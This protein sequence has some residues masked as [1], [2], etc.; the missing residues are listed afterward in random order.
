MRALTS[1]ARHRPPAPRLPVHRHARRRQDH[2][3]AHPGEVAQLRD[4]ACRAEPCG[5]CRACIEIDEGAFTDYLELDAASNRGVDEMTQLLENAVYAPAVGRYKVYVIDEV[6]MLSTHAFNAMLKTL[7]E[8]PPHMVFILATTDPQKVPVTVLSR[9][10]QFNLKNMPPAAI[11]RHLATVLAGR[12]RRVRGAGA[13]ADRPR[14]GGQHAR[15]AVAARPGDRLRRRRRCA[16][17]RSARCSAWS[18]VATSA[19]A[20]RA[21]GRRR[22]RR[23]SRVADEMMTSNAPFGRT[24]MTS[25][26]WLQRDRAR[27]RWARRRPRT[28]HFARALCAARFAPEDLQVYYQIADPRRARP[29]A[30][31]RRARRVHDDAAA[32]ARVRPE[33]SRGAAAGQGG[34]ASGRQAALAPAPRPPR[35]AR[36]REPQ[37]SRGL[38]SHRAARRAGRCGA[39]RRFAFR[40][41]ARRRRAA[42]G[43]GRRV[44]ARPAADGRSRSRRR[45]AGRRRVGRFAGPARPPDRRFDGDWPALAAAAA[46]RGSRR[47]NSC[48]R[49][50]SSVTMA[51]SFRFACRSPARR[52]RRIVAKVRQALSTHFG[53]PVR[54]GV[55]RRRGRAARRSRRRPNEPG[56]ERLAT[57]RARRSSP[58][59]SCATLIRRSSAARIVPESVARSRP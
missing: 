39:R 31:A 2:D 37:R 38:T 18:I 21:R 28:R 51:W 34:S 13:R 3:R 27:C 33:R 57:A 54:L 7:E 15:R 58:I 45:C 48:S 53:A 32:D 41:F 23:W 8:P 9:C 59:R 11:A 5:K 14:R 55:E 26:A 47:G 19:A 12:G 24:L 50:S 36:L 52:R 43:R 35:P 56:H 30:R 29:A 44:S 42:A 1:R 25:P 6:H 49:A 4:R 17:A 46:G 20:R 16:R 10:L 40:R 22:T